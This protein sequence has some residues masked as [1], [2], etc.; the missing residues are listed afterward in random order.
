MSAGVVKLSRLLE[1]PVEDQDGRSLSH[2]HDVRVRRTDAG[3]YRV[4]D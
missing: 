4:K 3:G 2:V 1:L